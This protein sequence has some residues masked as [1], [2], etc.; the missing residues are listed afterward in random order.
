MSAVIYADFAR[1]AIHREANAIRPSVETRAQTVR[2]IVLQRCED[3][4]GIS[5]EIAHYWASQ[6]QQVVRSNPARETSSVADNAYRQAVQ[7]ATARNPDPNK[8]A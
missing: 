5:S 3:H 7:A 6:A 4:G 8:A 2:R 1:R